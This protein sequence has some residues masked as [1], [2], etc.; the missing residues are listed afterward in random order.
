MPIRFACPECHQRLSVPV[1]K[2]DQDVKCPRCRRIVQV[3]GGSSGAEREL[4]ERRGGESADAWPAPAPASAADSASWAG[5]R[6]PAGAAAG[7]DQTVRVPRRVVY[8]QGFL[9]G[10]VA[11][12]FYV[13]GM[14]VGS[15][16]RSESGGAPAQPCTIS[17]TIQYEDSA[18]QAVP[19]ASSVV[20]VV[21]LAARPDQK[22]AAAGLRVSDPAP[23]GAHPGVA[24]I[25]SLG[26][27]YGRVD[28]RGRYRLRVTA[29]GRYYLLV[30]SQHAVRTAGL[31][32]DA[33]DLAQIGRYVVPATSLLDD[34]QYTWQELRI[35][36]DTTFDCTF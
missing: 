2:A 35:R 28:R 8:L 5:G 36:A 19:D 32:P 12:V 1:E 29:P 23:G 16:S 17:G 4:P 11:L 15:S 20:L 21:P 31:Q 34:Q 14:V 9:L 3:P 10:L 26:G 22:A 33:G 30:I 25:R 27:D 24:M 6:G 7:D 13:F 18:R